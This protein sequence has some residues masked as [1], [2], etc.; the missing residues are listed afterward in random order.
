MKTVCNN[1]NT[2]YRS[3]KNSVC[4]AA[5]I[6]GR[7]KH[8]TRLGCLNA[9]LAA[10][11]RPALQTTTVRSAQSAQKGST[12]MKKLPSINANRAQ[13]DSFKGQSKVIDARAAHEAFISEILRR[14]NVTRAFEDF[15]RMS[16]GVRQYARHAWQE[17]TKTW[18]P[19][20]QCARRV[21]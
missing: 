11:I 17:D 20:L 8:H 14:F 12:W 1:G 18:K 10:V 2:M 6:N 13:E 3:S 19:R 7:T 9:K 5:R 16:S 4:Q 15:T 21:L